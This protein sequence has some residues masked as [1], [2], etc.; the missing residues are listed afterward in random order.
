MKLDQVPLQQAV[1]DA[2]SLLEGDIAGKKAEIA[3]RE[4]GQSVIAHRATLVL[5]IT[6]FIA[7]AL[8][9]VAATTP[10]R[11]V[12]DSEAHGSLVRLVVEDNG[13]GIE[14]DEINKLFCVFQRLRGSQ[15]YAGNGLGLAI[16]HKGAERMGGSVGV[17]SK[18]GKGSRFWVE[19]R[20]AAPAP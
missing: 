15:E 14:P 18:P 3:V 19:L 5:I 12:I 16:V 7:N 2:L 20:A 8:K 17:N 13:I 1:E 6:N 11:I 9:F 10:P 4:L